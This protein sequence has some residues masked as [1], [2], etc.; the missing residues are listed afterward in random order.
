MLPDVVPENMDDDVAVVHQDPLRGPRA[1]DATCSGARA[2]EDAVDV[3]GDGTR[4][5]IRTLQSL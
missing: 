1:F 4:L 5:A 3:I 2:R